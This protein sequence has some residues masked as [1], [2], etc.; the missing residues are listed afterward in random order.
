M[1][2]IKSAPEL[3]KLKTAGRIVAQTLALIKTKIAPGVT[4]EE[5][6]REAALFIEQQ[7]AR[8]AFKGYRGYPKNICASINE[9][10]V[11][12]IPGSRM[13][14]RGDIIS[15]DVGVEWQGYFGDAAATYA[16]GRV[17]ADVQRLM[18]VTEESLAQGISQAVAGNHVG[19]ISAAVQRYVEAAG[20]SIVRDFVGH[21]I[22]SS[23][24][25]E[26]QIPNFETRERGVI[27][28]PGMV[29]AIEPMVNLGAWQVEVQEDG[30][31]AVTQ[32]R[33]P[34]AHFEHTICVTRDKPL[35][36]TAA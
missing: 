2:P 16:V 31:T 13:L 32:D 9:E 30:W 28:Q 10:V 4:T 5:L 6:D 24:H 19:D 21:G 17:S 25:E 22:G 15:I 7:G 12:G 29:L 18:R 26:P 35:I 11:H 23:L 33:K 27:L 36:L 8:P 3:E 1:I 20:F 34:S 14:R